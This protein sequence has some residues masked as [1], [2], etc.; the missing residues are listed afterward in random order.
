MN[1][2][3]PVLLGL[4]QANGM[5][6]KGNLEFIHKLEKQTPEEIQ[7]FQQEQLKKILQHAAEKVPYY[8]KILTK[9]E[10]YA[11]GKIN[12]KNFQKIPP[13]NKEIIRT[14]KTN[15]HSTDKDARQW[16]KNSSG[17]STG[18][19]VE[20]IQ[21]R[22]YKAWS[23]AGKMYFNLLAGKD[24]G[25]REVRIWGSERDIISGS[26]TKRARFE[27]WLYN[28]TI[29]NSFKMTPQKMVNYAEIINS[30]KP[31]LIE[32]YVQPMYQFAIFLQENNLQ[33]RSPKGIITS[34][35]TLTPS[36]KQEIKKTFK[37]SVHNKYGS[38]EVGDMAC[39]CEKD[40]GLHLNPA[41][42]VIEILDDKMQ[43]VKS[44]EIGSVYVTTLQ[45]YSMPLIR[46]KIGDLAVSA[47]KTICSCGR[48]LPLIQHVEGREMSVF[49]KKDG[50]IIPAEFFIHFIGVVHNKGFIEK[51]QVIQ[52]DY[53]AIT[54]KAVIK[55][56]KE[57]EKNKDAIEKSIRKTMGEKCEIKW[58]QVN[59]IPPLK[60]GKYLYTISKIK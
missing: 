9:S 21:D 46:Y 3:K 53:E 22:N 57:F 19:P 8:S 31:L 33:I 48:N 24:V 37:C 42:H 44:G 1:W 10:V 15:L 16:Y 12:L 54:I 13:L 23:F 49:K 58:E 55:N 18:E 26:Q 51:F 30:E 60:S 34:A 50:T 7:K 20:L 38:R 43:P 6:V 40:E 11:D 32:S 35:G 56:K 17:G 45:N 52:E 25:E 59:E 2:R 14:Q 47:R 41:T 36:M 28:R 29:L 27:N 4:M 39:S 5:N